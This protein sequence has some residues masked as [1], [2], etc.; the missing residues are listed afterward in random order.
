MFQ[1]NS[2]KALAP[3]SA[4]ESDV[5]T[6]VQTIAARGYVSCAVTTT[7][8][9]RCWGM[10]SNGPPYHATPTPICL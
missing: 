3:Q 5:L 7:S 8:G 9:A 4:P 10:N 2:E 6:G 1:G